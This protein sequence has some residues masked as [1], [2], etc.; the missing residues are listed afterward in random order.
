MR[1][2]EEL[3]TQDD[4]TFIAYWPLFDDDGVTLLNTTGWTARAEIRNR[5]AEL[6]ETF[7]VALATGR[8]ELKLSAAIRTWQSAI[9]DIR[10]QSPS[11]DVS[12]PIF[13]NI[14]NHNSVT[15]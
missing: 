12:R 13:G 11:G 15:R 2:T 14:T 8:I 10:I 5:H 3:N 7:Q 6:L 1:E 9:F 4:T